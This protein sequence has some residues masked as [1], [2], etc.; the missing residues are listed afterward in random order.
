VSTRRGVTLGGVGFSLTELRDLAAAWVVL[1]LAFTVV[2]NYREIQ[3]ALRSGALDP[4]AL[5]FT[6]AISVITVGL[7]VV[8]HEVGH[9]V[10]AIRFGQVAEF[11]ADYNML[12]FALLGS[13]LGFVFAAPGAVHHRGYLT[14]RQRGLI[15][16]AGPMV[17]VVL[18]VGFY[19]LL[20]LGR[21]APVL[22]AVGA[23][24]FFINV[25]LAAFN[26]IPFGPLDG[27]KVLDWSAAVFAGVFA[28]TA[29]LT[30]HLLGVVALP[31]SGLPGL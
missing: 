9:K 24:G 18:G 8:L 10:V 14:G 23:F 12:V 26:M 15:A 29:I 31:L 5:V 6:F 28:P 7:G 27:R 4:A 20:L 21:G 22:G 25:F 1:A 11:R 17:N 19:L 16:L 30:L 2:L 3:R 13:L